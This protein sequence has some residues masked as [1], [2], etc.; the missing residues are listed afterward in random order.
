MTLYHFDTLPVHPQPEPLESLSSYLTRLVEANGLR[1]IENLFRLCFPGERARLTLR[2]GDFPPPSFGGL[3]TLAQCPE[4]DLLATTLYHLGRKFDRPLNSLALAQALSG[5]ISPQLRYCPLCLAE[6]GYYLL[7]WRFLTVEGCPEHGCQLLERCGYCRQAV[8]LL[9]SRPKLGFCPT[10]GGDL[11]WCPV[12][13][14]DPNRLKR[15]INRVED[16]VYLLRPQPCE[17]E[18]SRLTP[19][20]G[21]RLSQWRQIRRLKIRD[22][23]DMLEVPPGIIYYLEQQPEQRSTKFQWYLDYAEVLGVSLRDIFL[24]AA[25]DLE[26]QSHAEKLLTK[27]RQAATILEQQDEV[28]TQQAVLKIIG[29]ETKIIFSQYPQIKAVWAEIKA[30][31]RQRFEQKLLSQVQQAIEQLRQHQQP[32]TEKAIADLI[33]R[34]LDGKLKKNYPAVQRLLLQHRDTPLQRP[35]TYPDRLKYRREAE[36]LGKVQE[37]IAMLEHQDQTVSRQSIANQVGLT[38][39]A[40]SH[41]PQ[42]KQL[43]QQYD[44]RRKPQDETT[45]LH[46]VQDALAH[47]KSDEVPITIEAVSQRL[48]LSSGTLKYYPQVKAFLTEHILDKKQAYHAEQRQRKEAELVRKVQQAIETMGAGD[49]RISQRMVCDRVGMSSVNLKRYPQVNR[50]LRQIVDPDASIEVL[51][52]RSG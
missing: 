14:I 3:P 22:I 27:V 48:G 46:K 7:P 8:P 35:R 30:Q 34:S 32:V 44:G 10:C 20:I 12:E 42:V 26:F 15:V 51:A 17:T 16:L 52:D 36:L 9:I 37:A 38:R 6:R 18:L 43:L 4:P 1:R 23:A 11:R 28:I 41:Y 21:R 2:T 39:Q 29:V 25:P 5:S 13:K 33:G 19:V 24:L 49:N 47:L 40:L 45:L 50:L 31:E